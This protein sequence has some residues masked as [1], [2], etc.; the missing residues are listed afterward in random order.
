MN[1]IDINIM[2]ASAY[3]FSD[4]EKSVT[5]LNKAKLILPSDQRIFQL[6]NVILRNS[7]DFEKRRLCFVTSQISWILFSKKMSN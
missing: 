3:Q 6:A 1:N 7:E 4:Q 5:Y 2:L